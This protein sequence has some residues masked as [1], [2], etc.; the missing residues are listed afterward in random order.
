LDSTPCI[1]NRGPMDHGSFRRAR[2]CTPSLHPF[3][4]VFLRADILRNRFS[5][6][7]K[8]RQKPKKSASF[9]QT[10]QSQK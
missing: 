5:N 8:S 2:R 1:A 3:S 6:Q 9:D 7:R 4:Y 10:C